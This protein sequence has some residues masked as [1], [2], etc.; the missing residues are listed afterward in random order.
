[1]IKGLDLEM[2]KLFLD[3]PGGPSLI[4]W[5]F[6]SGRCRQKSGSKGCALRTW[7]T[8]AADF[9]DG[10]RGPK[11]KECG[12]PLE[13]GKS[14]KSDSPLEPQKSNSGLLT[15]WFQPRSDIWPTDSKI[16]LFCFK[17]LCLWC[18]V[19]QHRKLIYSPQPWV[20]LNNPW[21]Y[22]PTGSYVDVY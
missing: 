21:I 18:I 3:Y 19:Y 1:M 22:T 9:E 11:V 17:L 4:T 16:N 15:P 8:G 14:K 5:V 6:K 12:K 7:P 10:G 13:A 2:G 20:E